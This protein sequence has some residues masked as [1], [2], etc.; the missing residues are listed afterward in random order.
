[1]QS[2]AKTVQQYLASLPEE[3]RATVS[4][5]RDVIRRNLPKGYEEGMQYGMIGW[6]VPHSIYPAGYH[7]DPRQ[8]LPFAGLAAQKNYVSLY[9]HSIYGI[10]EERRRFA[11]EWTRS[12]KKLDMGK[13]CIRFQRLDDVP[14]KVVGD[15]VKRV[16]VAKLVASY[17]AALQLVKRK[18]APARKA[19]ATKKAAKKTKAATRA[20]AARKAR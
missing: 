10:D 9:L 12:G 17:E 20:K 7:C 6:H 1:M 16:P 4:A 19:A 5:V 13:A 3:R 15:A 2:R 14:L 8:P 11:E 18:P